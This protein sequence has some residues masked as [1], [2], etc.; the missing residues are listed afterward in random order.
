MA[1]SAAWQELLAESVD[2]GAEVVPA[3]TVRTT[4]RRLAR[5]HDLDDDGK[6][7]LRSLVGAVERFWYGGR[8]DPDPDLP[9]AFDEV[10]AAL[11]RTSPLALRGRLLPRSVTRRLRTA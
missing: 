6:R 4:A 5:E 1:P 3:E 10:V 11:R 2:R 7:A 8:T 9:R